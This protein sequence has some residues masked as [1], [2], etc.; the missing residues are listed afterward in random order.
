M[1]QQNQIRPSYSPFPL[2]AKCEKTINN[3]MVKDYY[4]MIR[5]DFY[6]RVTKLYRCENQKGTIRKLISNVIKFWTI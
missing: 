3:M 6:Q 2:P 4:E 1:Q 5:P